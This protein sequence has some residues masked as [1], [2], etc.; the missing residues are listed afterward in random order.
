VSTSDFTLKAGGTAY[1]MLETPEALG[2]SE[3]R[4]G[5]RVGDQ[6][7]PG[8][9]VTYFTIYDVPPDATDLHLTFKQDTHPVFAVGNATL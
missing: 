9:S 4:G 3:S 1:P 7:A 8:V 5:R 6:I 2:Y